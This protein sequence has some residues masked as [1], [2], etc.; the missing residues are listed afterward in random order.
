MLL[1]VIDNLLTQFNVGTEYR[2][3]VTGLIILIAVIIGVLAK[4]RNPR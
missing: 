1:R 2:K 3:V 4:R